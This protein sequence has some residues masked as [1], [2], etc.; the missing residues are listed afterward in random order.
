MRRLSAAIAALSIA[1]SSPA[2]AATIDFNALAFGGPVSGVE[3]GF[4]ITGSARSYI[5]AP[6]FGFPT[7]AVGADSSSGAT[8]TITRAGQFMFDQMLILNPE[9]FAGTIGPITVA[10]FVGVTAVGTDT[11]TAPAALSTPTGYFASTLAGVSVDR[12]VLTFATGKAPM[13]DDIVLSEPAAAP[14]STP[15]PASALLLLAG[16]AGLAAR[17]R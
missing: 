12:I 6:V 4:T 9:G 2:A 5:W 15:E 1:A 7:P 17:R 13:V 11:F 8:L 3:D 10:G 14:T 16:L